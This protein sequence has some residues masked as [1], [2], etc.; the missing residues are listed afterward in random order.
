MQTHRQRFRK[1][2]IIVAVKLPVFFFVGLTFPLLTIIQEN[3]CKAIH[4]SRYYFLA[5]TYFFFAWDL[6]LTPIQSYSSKYDSSGIHRGKIRQVEL[7]TCWHSRF[8]KQQRNL[9]EWLKSN[10]IYWC[11]HMVFHFFGL[12][13]I[14]DF[15]K[16]LIMLFGQR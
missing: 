15:F 1:W 16:K 14:L 13:I 5:F 9:D 7:K 3:I 11:F 12:P 8:I 10:C 4:L 6:I 2:V